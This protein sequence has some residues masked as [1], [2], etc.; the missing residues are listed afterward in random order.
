[1]GIPLPAGTQWEIVEESAQ[2]IK[3]ARD[4]LIR[5]AAQGTV[6]HNDDTGM[7]VL[8]LKRDPSGA[9]IQPGWL[10]PPQQHRWDQQ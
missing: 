7:R 8:T 3:P 6:V 9:Y 4:E 2:V 1:M 5:Q 10:R